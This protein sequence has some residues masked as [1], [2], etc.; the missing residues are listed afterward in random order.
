MTITGFLAST[1]AGAVTGATFGLVTAPATIGGIGLSAGTTIETGIAVKAGA[2]VGAGIVGGMAGRGVESGF[3]TE[4]TIGTPQQI[5]M[6]AGGALFNET[7]VG[8]LVAPVV[9]TMTTAG[10]A[11][12]VGEANV[13]R[14]TRPS[15]SLP[16]RQA[17]LQKQQQAAAGAVS[18][19][20]DAAVKA[21]QTRQQKQQEEE[22]RRRQQGS[23]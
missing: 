17:Q 5:G 18:A 19:G 22:Q 13:A 2:S 3:D 9:K 16:E 20:G 12:S 21:Q 10:R 11:V 23:N 6:D 15:R 7:V 14:G 1:S 8:P 4:K